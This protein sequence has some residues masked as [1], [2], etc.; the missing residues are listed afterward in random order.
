MI[1]REALGRRVREVWVAT[2]EELLD[3]PKPSWTA[4]WEEIDGFQREVDMRI[5]EAIVAM[6]RA[7]D[8]P[9]LPATAQIRAWLLSHDWE[10]VSHGLAGTLWHL[11][12]R[13]EPCVGVPDDDDDPLLVAGALKRIAERS[14]LSLDSLTREMRRLLRG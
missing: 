4:P 2:A 3:N 8:D 7:E 5:G 10:L 11:R 9:P 13:G 6:V 12:R 14:H 1:D